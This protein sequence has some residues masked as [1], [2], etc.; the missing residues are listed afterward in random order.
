MQKMLQHAVSKLP[1]LPVSGL[2]LGINVENRL[3][4]TNCFANPSRAD[5]EHDISASAIAGGVSGADGMAEDGL[6]TTASSSMSSAELTER[7][8]Q[9]QIETLHYLKDLAVDNNTVGWYQ[10]CSLASMSSG[11]WLIID[12]QYR[13][14]LAFGQRCICLLLDPLRSHS[15]HIEIKAIRLKDKFM[16]LVKK[17][18]LASTEKQALKRTKDEFLQDWLEMLK[19]DADLA[20]A[21]LP[22]NSLDDVFITQEVLDSLDVKHDDIF[23]E[24]PVR[25]QNR[26]LSGAF[27][28]RSSPVPMATRPLPT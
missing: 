20:F 22:R 1:T 4:I 19:T 8:R 11:S 6:T 9:Y 25:I 10:S 23:E 12:N 21:M 3:E 7:E 15:G 18:L 28:R 24:V 17:C 13:H 26:A 27:C 5:F 2:L 16:Q 14:Q